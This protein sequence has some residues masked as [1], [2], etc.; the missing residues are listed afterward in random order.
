MNI[1]IAVCCVLIA[2]VFALTRETFAQL[3]TSVSATR[4]HDDNTFGTYQKLSDDVTQFYLNFS[5]DYDGDYSTWTLSYAGNLNLFDKYSFRNYHVHGLGLDYTLQLNP[6]EEKEEEE[7]STESELSS[8]GT[9][10]RDSSAATSN[11]S[12]KNYFYAG[13]SL[14]GRF[15]RDSVN[16]YNNGYASSYARLRW[17]LSDSLV[18]HVMYLIGYRNYLNLKE[19]SNLENS[20][21]MNLSANLGA[22]KLSATA[23]YS[24]KKYLST[25]TDTTELVKLGVTPGGVGPG[26]GKGK[27]KGAGS[28]SGGAQSGEVQRGVVITQLSTP[29]SSSIGFGAGLVQRIGNQTEVGLRYFR[30]TSP[31]L[32]G[33]YINGQLR[34]YGP[35]DEI[36]DDSYTYQSHLI[37]GSLKQSFAWAMTLGIEVLYMPKTY[38]RPAFS[39]PDSLGQSVELSSTRKD[40]RFELG[41]ELEQPFKFKNGFAKTLTIQFG[42]YFVNNRSNDDFY[43]FTDNLFSVGIETDF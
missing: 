43:R 8:S 5:K 31:S 41:L 25:T 38:G 24:Y 29:G 9:H 40:D 13:A 4:Q 16:Y 34:G 17:L 22:T 23:G 28:G 1:R 27:G 21:V 15:D 19:L 36:Y 11:D 10:S 14:A 32:K 20:V 2:S 30:Q 39:L 18:S 33:R 42:Y 26:K 37:V 6:E 3:E 7:D 12:L 35:N